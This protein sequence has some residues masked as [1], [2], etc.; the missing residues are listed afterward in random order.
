LAVIIDEKESA[1]TNK[2]TKLAVNW[3]CAERLLFCCK[4]DRQIAIQKDWITKYTVWFEKIF[5]GERSIYILNDLVFVKSN[6]VFNAVSVDLQRK[7]LGLGKID[8][9]PP[10]STVDL[11]KLSAERHQY[12]VLR[13][14]M[15]CF[16]KF[17]SS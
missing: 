17:G 11:Q 5:Q 14:P 15:D 2:S 4:K 8:H 3:Q 13:H 12:S 9:H 16:E 1:S 6:D 7:G 10:I